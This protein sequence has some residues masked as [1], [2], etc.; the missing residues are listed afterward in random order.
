MRTYP[1]YEQMQ[2]EGMEIG[3]KTFAILLFACSQRGDVGRAKM[4]WDEMLQFG[5][6]P[7]VVCYNTMLNVYAKSNL[8]GDVPDVS[9]DMMWR[10]HPKLREPRMTWEEYMHLETQ[11]YTLLDT[12]PTTDDMKEMSEEEKASQLRL[13]GGARYEHIGEKDTGHDQDVEYQAGGD[14]IF[15]INT[16]REFRLTLITFIF[17]TFLKIFFIYYYRLPL[18]WDAYP[19]SKEKK[20]T[21]QK[22]NI[23]GKNHIK[24]FLILLLN[25]LKSLLFNHLKLLLL[26]FI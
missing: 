7:N 10:V 18:T 6:E 16:G 15:K 4:Y 21:L 1:I 3:V 24:L 2:V 25:H 23:A 5:I 17:L 20:E 9:K 11:D 14:S 19:N 22:R 12:A 26:L 8:L 13:L